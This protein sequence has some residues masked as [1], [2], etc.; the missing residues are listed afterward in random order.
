M[1]Q[2]WFETLASTIEVAKEQFNQGCE[3]GL[4]VVALT[5][6][7]GRGQFER[8]FDDQPKQALLYSQV[9]Y[10]SELPDDFAYCVG[11]QLK[12][13][14]QATYEI[15]VEVKRPN[16]LYY[17]QYKLAGILLEP[18]YLGMKLEG[19]IVS[20]GLNVHDIPPTQPQAT[21]LR[22]IRNQP[23]ELTTIAS[24]LQK[25]LYQACQNSNFQ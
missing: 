20:V 24:Q 5:Q 13:F 23:Y 3:Q 14:L 10:L 8:G 11:K 15:E 22:M 2:L 7:C 19:V 25:W 6:T 1:K 18:Q 12:Q 4:I 21:C 17:E 16:D 9:F